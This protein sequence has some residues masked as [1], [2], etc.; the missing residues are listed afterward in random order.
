MGGGWAPRQEIMSIAIGG[1]I[2][3]KIVADKYEP[4]T[5]DVDRTTCF[6][7]HILNSKSF[8]SITGHALPP[9]PLDAEFCAR[10]NLRYFKESEELIV[11][12]VQPIIAWEGLKSISQI[13]K[14]ND[15]SVEIKVDPVG[16]SRAFSSFLLWGAEIE[17]SRQ[18]SLEYTEIRR[19]EKKCVLM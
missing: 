11:A 7:L 3:Q 10:Q 9:T 8:R 14:V 17:D 13:L 18:R 4:N 1:Y 12:N 5:W 2:R 6:N 15:S 19:K 16:P